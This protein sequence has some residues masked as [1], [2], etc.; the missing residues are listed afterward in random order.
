MSKP[1]RRHRNPVSH[2]SGYTPVTWEP[3]WQGDGEAAASIVA[4]GL[5][6]DGIRAQVQ[7]LRAA[8][9]IRGQFL[10]RN[11]WS[12]FVLSDHADEARRLLRKR[13]D[14][15]NIVTTNADLMSSQI[16]TLKFAAV[17]L[18]VAA[19][20]VLLAFVRYGV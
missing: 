4:G 8:G 2:D 17:G 11:T 14:D 6:A 7:G 18:L 5:E 1:S 13:H 9:G 15:P 16:A 12:V 10:A 20:V 19:V 3:V